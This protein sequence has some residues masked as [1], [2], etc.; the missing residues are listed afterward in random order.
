[1]QPRES[2]LDCSR[3]V[4]DPVPLGFGASS[5]LWGRDLFSD[6]HLSLW[7]LRALGRLLHE[8]SRLSARV[9]FPNVPGSGC[10]GAYNSSQQLSNVFLLSL[11]PGRPSFKP[12][13]RL[14]HHLSKLI[15]LLPV[16]FQIEFGHAW[17]RTGNWFRVIRIPNPHRLMSPMY[18]GVGGF[19]D[20]LCKNYSGSLEHCKG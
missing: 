5:F 7:R 8:P 6:L 18:K 9:D 10:S 15:S 3:V 19:L 17:M 20:D 1:M 13:E 16:S 12:Q 2:R 11:F 4:K 14:R